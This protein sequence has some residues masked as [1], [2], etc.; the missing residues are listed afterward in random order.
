MKLY[1]SG[2]MS[3][4][5]SF[6][7]PA[8]NSAAKRL[9]EQGHEVIVPHEEDV[10]NGVTI[11]ELM[12]S[13]HG[14]TTELTSKITWGECLARDVKLI[15]DAGVEAIVVLPGWCNSRGARL[16][17]YTALLCELPV[18]YYAASF[19]VPMRLLSNESICSELI[20]EWRTL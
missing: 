15:A 2:P 3:G 5:K 13:E 1:L 9:R 11:N 7:I 4:I 14:D 17:V 16:E 10:N 8:F 18:F 20:A 6:N 19:P 12:A